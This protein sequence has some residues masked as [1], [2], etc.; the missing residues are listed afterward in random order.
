MRIGGH[1]PLQKLASKFLRNIEDIKFQNHDLIPTKFA[2]KYGGNP[3]A[4]ECI[5]Y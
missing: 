4:Q 1:L 2:L 3:H 5:F